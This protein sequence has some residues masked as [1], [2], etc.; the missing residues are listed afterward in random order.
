MIQD[1]ATGDICCNLNILECKLVSCGNQK[2]SLTGC[3][4]NILECKYSQ[5]KK[6]AISVNVVI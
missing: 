5:A 3:N 2:A 6:R 4:L 1:P